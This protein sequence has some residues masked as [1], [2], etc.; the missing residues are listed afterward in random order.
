MKYFYERRAFY[1]YVSL[2]LFL[3]LVPTRSDPWYTERSSSGEGEGEGEGEGDCPPEC[4]D[5]RLCKGGC[6]HT[7]GFWET[8]CDDQRCNADS[9]AP[10]PILETTPLCGSNDIFSGATW[11]DI[12]HTSPHRNKC[13]IFAHQYIVTKLN[14]ANGTCVPDHISALLLE[15]D[16]LFADC[17]LLDCRDSTLADK[18]DILAAYNEGTTGP[19]HCDDPPN[20]PP[21]CDNGCPPTTSGGTTTGGTGTAT[22]S[23]TAGTTTITTTGGTTTGDTTT[24]GTATT[25][26]T[27]TGP[28]PTATTT[29]TSTTSGQPPPPPPPPTPPPPTPPPPTPSCH[30]DTDC[31]D[32]D[33]CTEDKCINYVCQHNPIPNCCVDNTECR[34]RNPCTQDECMYNE[35]RHTPIPDCCV[36]DT[37]CRDHDICTDDKCVDNECTHTEIPD[38]CVDNSDCRDHNPCTQDECMYNECQ[39]TPIPDCC[40][41][42]TDCRDR[43]PCT[44]DECV[45]NVCRNTPIPD[46]CVQDTDCRDRDPCTDDKCVDYLCQNTPIPD[47]C[48]EDTDCRDREPCT[49]DKCEDNVCLNTPIPD[50]CVVDT[51]CRD[52]NLCTDDK[53]ED[54]VCQNTPIPDCCIENTDCRDRD[55]CTEDE[56]L[57]NVCQNTPIPDCCVEDTDC[58]DSNVCTDDKCVD[59]VCQNTPIP[60]CCE[61]DGD[62]N[63]YNTCTQDECFDNVCRNTPIPDCCVE[64]TECGDRDPCTQDSCVQNVC[65]NDPIPDCCEDDSDCGDRDT[66]TLDECVNHICQNNPIPNCCVTHADCRDGD[67]CTLDECVNYQCEHTEIPDCCEHDSDCNDENRCTRDRCTDNVCVFTEISNCCLDN[68]DCRDRD[69]CTEDECVHHNCEHNPIPD[70][71]TDDGDC[72]DRDPCTEDRCFD[73]ACT[74]TPIPGCC[75]DDGD[76]NDYDACTEDVCDPNHQCR[77]PPIICDD[78]N[79]CTRDSCDPRSGCVFE[80]KNCNTGRKCFNDFCNGQTG[81]CESEPIECGDDDDDG[82]TEGTCNPRTG[83]CASIPM[84]CDDNEACTRD[85]CVIEHYEPVCKNVP[86]RDCNVTDCPHEVWFNVTDCSAF[87]VHEFPHHVWEFCHESTFLGFEGSAVVL[88]FDPYVECHINRRGTCDNRIAQADKAFRLCLSNAQTDDCAQFGGGHAFFIPGLSTNLRW[89]P[90]SNPTLI[91]HPQNG[92]AHMTGVV[93]DNDLVLLVDVWFGVLIDPPPFPPGSPFLELKPE[94]YKT[95]GGDVN[96]DDWRFY[97]R[98]SGVLTGFPNTPYEGLSVRISITSTAAQFGGGANGKNENAGMSAWFTW[99]VLHQPHNQALN[100]TETGTR[101]D[102]NIDITHECDDGGDDYCDLLT[103]QFPSNGWEWYLTD[104]GTIVYCRNFTLHDLLNCRAFDNPYDRLFTQNT[105]EGRIQYNGTL[106]STTVIDDGCQWHPE[107]CGERTVLNTHFDIE[108]WVD[109]N[110]TT[111]ISFLG[112]HLKFEAHWIRNVWLTGED[113]GDLKVVVGMVVN[114]IEQRRPDQIRTTRL[115]NCHIVRESETGF[116]LDIVDP[117]PPCD[118]D[119]PDANHR[120]HQEFCLRSHGAE[121]VLDF[122]GKKTIICTVEV[123]GEPRI[124]VTAHMNLRA[125]HTGV[126]THLDGKID[127]RLQLYTDDQFTTPY[128]CEDQKHFTFID[129]ERLFGVLRLIYQQH[130]RVRISKVWLCY[131]F[132]RDLIPFDPLHPSITGCHTLGADIVHRL[133]FSDDPEEEDDI[134]QELHDF[135]LH[136]SPPNGPHQQG[137]SFISHAFTRRKM[138]IQVKWFAEEYGGR[139]ALIERITEYRIDDIKSIVKKDDHSYDHT[140]YYVHCQEGYEYDWNSNKCTNDNWHSG[141]WLLAI[142]FLLLTVGLVSWIIYAAM[143]GCGMCYGYGHGHGYGGYG[144]YGFSGCSD[145]FPFIYAS[146][147]A[148]YDDVYQHGA[149]A[150]TTPVPQQQQQQNVTVHKT[151]HNYYGPNVRRRVQAKTEQSEKLEQPASVNLDQPASVNL[152]EWRLVEL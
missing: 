14:E 62:C 63:D 75:E 107:V 81:E 55:L 8:H 133:L 117:S 82:C 52:R 134:D 38:C 92:T 3:F 145:W 25:T 76:C 128:S 59:N 73:N 32:G 84:D 51:D 97:R 61:D 49:D 106:F 143:G 135:Q 43:D 29:T 47:C 21:E 99:E 48:V 58:R 115:I 7:Y 96:P 108:I 136:H 114:H 11:L 19:G 119:A 69:P 37:D 45:D 120:C 6:T 89:R 109:T 57:D 132:D 88:G 64:D 102:I 74:Q 103:V 56:C 112:S 80:P 85:F 71:C 127:A 131:A 87:W 40:V 26:R 126:L 39:H 101:G 93:Q 34:D 90:A 72:A 12:L 151:E 118:E 110:G 137:F 2:A 148:H 78:Y 147:E 146:P 31:R 30:A 140:N 95:N 41:D 144:G 68:S 113:R 10:W 5:E 141:H 139:G 54:N 27:T 122:S 98:M 125:K 53:C 67:I 65:Q 129:C 91:E 24:S 17:S 9:N 46:C 123:C 60:D 4:E 86:I 1:I 66:C 13:I 94:C 77:H 42:N 36:E 35:C 28:P 130:L 44:E 142:I 15:G 124:N 18:G 16:E 116:P 111:S 104:N 79:P 105:T 150:H 33:I 149:G 23:T 100:V 20:V 121:G 50:C 152:D 138:L 70:C 22:L 83:E